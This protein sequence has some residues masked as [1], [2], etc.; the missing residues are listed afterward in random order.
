MHTR[1]LKRTGHHSQD[2]ARMRTDLQPSRRD[3]CVDTAALYAVPISAVQADTM[4]QDEL[5][6]SCTSRMGY[7][8]ASGFVVGAVGGAVTSNW[9]ALHIARFHE[10]ILHQ[11]QLLSIAATNIR[12][13]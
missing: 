8:A 13:R 6:D 5:P 1:A 12:M 4:S 7:A 11:Q 10:A 9:G 2:T 3:C